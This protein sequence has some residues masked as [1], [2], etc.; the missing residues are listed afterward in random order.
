[1]SLIEF[2]DLP[3]TTTPLNSTNLNNNFNFFCNMITV[4]GP[5]ESITTTSDSQRVKISLN[6]TFAQ[7]GD[8]LSF[9]D[10]E[11]CIVIGEGVSYISV[12]CGCTFMPVSSS[13]TYQILEITKNSTNQSIR[14]Q[15]RGQNS[16]SVY[17]NISISDILIPV[18]QGDKISMTMFNR[19]AGEVNVFNRY[20]TVKVIK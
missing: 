9:N 10:G 12:S 5:D 8:K 18:S 4:S 14:A 7:V 17:G 16:P 2:K 20:L 1:M 19:V 11:D 6:S 15:V 3:D 13:T